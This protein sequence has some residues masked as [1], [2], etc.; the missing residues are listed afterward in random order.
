MA[1]GDNPTV[2]IYWGT[3]DGGNNAGSWT[4]H[5][6]PTSPIQPQGVSAFYY[7][8]TGLSAGTHRLQ[9]KAWTYR[10]VYCI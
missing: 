2:T 6:A 4:N 1:G 10:Q 5:P 7:N 8:L 9:Y 3:T